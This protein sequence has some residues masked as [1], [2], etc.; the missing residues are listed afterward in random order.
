MRFALNELLARWNLVFQ[1]NL[2]F[3]GSFLTENQDFLKYK[4][5]SILIINSRPRICILYFLCLSVLWNKNCLG[6]LFYNQIIYALN[7]VYIRKH[8]SLLA[9][10]KT[11][12]LYHLSQLI[13]W[14]TRTTIFTTTR[15]IFICF[16]YQK[17]LVYIFV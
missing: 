10:T 9:I 7:I 15:W 1:I 4:F 8:F 3:Q 11:I 13:Y 12:Q 6:N 5:I 17:I 14:Q 16:F 2:L